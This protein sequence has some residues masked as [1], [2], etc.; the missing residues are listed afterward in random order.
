[1]T[2]S[3]LS[4]TRRNTLAAIGQLGTHFVTTVFN[5][6]KLVQVFVYDDK[7]FKYLQQ[8]FQIAATQ[9]PDGSMAVSG[10]LAN[11]WI[12]YTS[13]VG[14]EGSSKLMAI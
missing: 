14:L 9:Q 3:S 8:Q 13:P 10:T 4:L 12:I 1:M 11:S 5:G 7:Q 2:A 6:D